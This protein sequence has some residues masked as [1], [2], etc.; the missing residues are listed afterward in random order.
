MP[1]PRVLVVG[2]SNAD[3]VL[4]VQR[5]PQPAETVLGD[6]FAIKPGGKGANQAVAAARAGA[7]VSFVARV[8]RDA[9]GAQALAGLRAEGVDV[10]GV[11]VDPATPTGVAMICV[12]RKGQN[13]IA[14]A[15]GANERLEPR[16]LERIDHL[17]RGAD[18]IVA[19]LEVPVETVGALAALA[20]KA[21]RP[22]IVNPAPA[23]KLPGS[24]L[25]QVAVLTPNEAEAGSLT[26]IVVTTRAAA[27]AAA[28]KLMATGVGAVV[29]TRG[30]RGAFV[31][32]PGLRCFVRAHPVTAT[33]STGAGDVFNGALAVALGEGL[34]LLE[35]VHFANA[36]AAISVT[37]LGAQDSAPR[38]R[39]IETWVR[40]HAAPDRLRPRG[41]R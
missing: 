20:H 14:V 22:L 19:Q 16:D 6:R 13:A 15:P 18:I 30:R 10:A 4:G 17:V 27:V 39:E 40:Q 37:R 38:R 34:P 33:D 29:I 2:S 11:V 25:R 41:G 28:D 8:G 5:L 1:K 26:G 24:L 35:S 12:D 7:R 32:G 9:F 31:A 21:G 3:M 36:A 23:R